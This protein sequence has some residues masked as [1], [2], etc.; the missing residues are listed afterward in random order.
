LLEKPLP[1]TNRTISAPRQFQSLQIARLTCMLAR[2]IGVLGA[3][4]KKAGVKVEFTGGGKRHEALCF[5]PASGGGR[6][7][8]GLT[9]LT[10]VG[11]RAGAMRARVN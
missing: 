4:T 10:L 9:Q 2:T 1:D 7:G 11:G 6:A 5:Y 8:A 3:K